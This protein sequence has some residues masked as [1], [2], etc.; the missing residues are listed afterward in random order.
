MSED[1]ARFLPMPDAVLAFIAAN[2]EAHELPPALEAMADEVRKLNSWI[3]KG[4]PVVNPQ[5]CD[6][7][8]P[9]VVP[10]VFERANMAVRRSDFK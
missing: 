3:R 5:K 9:K 4:D 8:V 6:R 1:P 10:A 2:N 7:F